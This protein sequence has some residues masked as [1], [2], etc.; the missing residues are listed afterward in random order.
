M[1]GKSTLLELIAG[2]QPT[3]GIVQKAGRVGALAELEVASVQNLLVGKC[4]YQCCNSGLKRELDE[5]MEEIV[6]FA[7][8]GSF[9]DR[10]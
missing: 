3:Q 9:I 6:D 1:A 10:P 5:K 7:D 4:T 2:I 8:I